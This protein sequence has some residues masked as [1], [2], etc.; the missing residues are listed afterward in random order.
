MSRQRI[1][2]AF[3]LV[4]V[5]ILG[6]VAEMAAA[7]LVI[8]IKI[9]GL[10]GVAAGS[11]S[12]SEG[13]PEGPSVIGSLAPFTL[14]GQPYAGALTFSDPDDAPADIT[15][16]VSGSFLPRGGTAIPF[17]PVTLANGAS[18]SEPSTGGLQIDRA[19][20]TLQAAGTAISAGVYTLEFILENTAGGTSDHVVTLTAGDLLQLTV[21]PP[22]ALTGQA[23]MFSTDLLIGGQIGGGTPAA[24]LFAFTRQIDGSYAESQSPLVPSNAGGQSVNVGP[25]AVDSGLAALNYGNLDNVLVARQSGGVWSEATILSENQSGEG[26]GSSLAVDDGVVFAGAA[27]WQNPDGDWM[28]RVYAY[29]DCFTTCQAPIAI[30]SPSTGNT[31]G[32]GARVAAD[33]G[34]L[35]ISD[36]YFGSDEGTVFIYR[37]ETGLWNLQAQL[38]WPSGLGPSDYR[39]T[40]YY[41]WGSTLAMAGTRL[42]V[43]VDGEDG[44]IYPGIVYNLASCSGTAPAMTCPIEAVLMPAADVDIWSGFGML[45]GIH[46]SMAVVGGQ[47]DI[48]LYDLEACTDTGTAMDC[49]PATRIVG[50]LGIAWNDSASALSHWGYVAMDSSWSG[51]YLMPLQ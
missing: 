37:R 9:P 15:I 19:S 12:E 13:G 40:P 46:G 50:P 21:A 43:G 3:G 38:R 34:W 18:W 36:P 10:D 17:G 31:G 26:F 24:A 42:V 23:A 48:N 1:L 25:I 14:L 51:H 22:G 7:N 16:S 8:R 27:S 44:D 30:D 20:G 41:E 39:D 33:E 28:G 35:A 45:V 29:A 5:V 6:G 11:G 2:G 4:I 32:F 49:Q 47:S